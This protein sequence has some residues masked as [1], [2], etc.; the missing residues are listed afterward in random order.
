MLH[1]LTP[2]RIVD[3]EGSVG[4]AEVHAI[5]DHVALGARQV[6]H[7]ELH[8]LI[9]GL[10]QNA[11]VL[12]DDTDCRFLIGAHML[13]KGPLHNA[14]LAGALPSDDHHFERLTHIYNSIIFI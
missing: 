7:L 5:E 12:L 2:S 8:L 11:E 9:Q 13:A 10:D 4:V 3:D 1:T 6:I 14:R